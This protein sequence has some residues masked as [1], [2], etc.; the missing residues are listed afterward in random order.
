MQDLNPCD[1]MLQLNYCL[2]IPTN[3]SDELTIIIND[4]CNIKNAFF[5]IK[6]SKAPHQ[7]DVENTKVK[8]EI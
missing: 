1:S 4:D 5:K 2:V 3:Y 8:V 6:I 7:I